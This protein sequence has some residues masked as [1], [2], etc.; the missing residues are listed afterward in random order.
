[1]AK[2]TK[3]VRTLKTH[4]H[5][6]DVDDEI[7]IKKFG[8]LDKFESLLKGEQAP[9]DDDQNALD[10]L[11]NAANNDLEASEVIEVDGDYDQEALHAGHASPD[12]REFSK[13]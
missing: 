13:F 6:F 1:M 5:Y 8:S 2:F 3:S 9:T 12:E 11:E 10:W 7:I 4:L